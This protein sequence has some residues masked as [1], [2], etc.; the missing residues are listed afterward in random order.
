MNVVT[1]CTL[2]C[3]DACSLLVSTLPDGTVRVQGNPNHP[4][5]AGFTCAKIRRFSQRLRS[6]Q[7]ITTPL[8]RQA[9]KWKSIAWEEALQLCAES[10]QK[11]RG[12]PESIL[13][14]PG[15]G[16]KGVLSQVNN[17]FFK[18][19][20][21]SEVDGSLCEMAGIA[22]CIADF[23]SLE[24]NDILDLANAR[25]I[26]NWGK[27]L[28]RSSTHVAALVRK[29]RQK[30]ARLLTISPGG[31]GNRSFS[32]EMIP[33]RP[34]TDR[35]LAAAVIYL[36]LHSGKIN[37][38]ILQRSHDWLPFRELITKG[39]VAQF[40]GVCEVSENE[41]ELVAE[42]YERSDP[43]ATLLGWG[44]QRYRYG[45]ENVRFI[46]ALAFLSGNF[47]LSGGGS[48]MNILSKR[49]FNLRWAESPER[50]KRRALLLPII[51]REILSSVDP[52]I[53]MIWVN[54]CNIVNQGPDSREIRRAFGAAEF[55]VV[56]DAFMTDTAEQ[57]DL[58]LPCQLMF[59]KEDVVGSFL[60]NYVNYVKPVLEPPEGA[61][62]DFWILSELGKR[63]EPPIL[64]PAPEDCLKASLD[65]AYLE[66]SF[67]DLRRVGFVRASRPY[68][69][70]EDLVFDNPD[71]KY[72]LPTE[73]HEE[74]SPPAEFPL[75]LL[76]LVRRNFIHSQL[77]PEDHAP[78]PFVLVAPHSRGLRGLDLN[79]EVF[80]VSPLGRIKV[81][82]KKLHG[83]HPDVVIYRRGD[84]MKLGGGAN[85]LI[86]ADLTDMGGC[87][88]Y[89]SQYVRLEK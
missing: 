41:V 61:R 44:L 87:A 71:G 30:G 48:Y 75:R 82:V 70:Y 54:G 15:E 1:A 83:V 7:R 40:A 10:I 86:A 33:I 67:E 4:I 27:D 76:T 9:K 73:L 78:L 79:Q 50:A 17:L 14:I 20:G 38:E 2:D 23:G 19:L 46:N 59:E 42:F 25:W 22:A 74:P 8:L 57:A 35:F 84:W 11:Y 32:D 89:Y 63:L 85:Q 68:I 60:H 39:S 28:S 43:V 53:R 45:G 69:A 37:S 55:K 6:T 49:N 3:P 18:S 16:D 52:P 29:A 58:V 88:A 21:A 66:A 56:V 77:L 72:H 12:A 47:G 62:S 80:L 5:T 24:T 64:L 65:S 34:G 36:L 13:H 51:G 26:V 31:D 81:E